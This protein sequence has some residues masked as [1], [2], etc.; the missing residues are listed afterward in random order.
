MRPMLLTL[1]AAM[2][3]PVMVAEARETGDIRGFLEDT[4]GLPVANARVVLKDGAISGEREV[5][6]DANGAFGF[7]NIP[8]GDYNL[9]VYWNDIPAIQAAVR[10]DIN[11]TTSLPLE[12]DLS[13]GVEEIE[14]VTF[15]PVIDSTSSANSASIGSEA[16]ENLPVGRDYR[17]VVAT[18][19]G[20]SGRTNTSDGDTNVVSPSVRGEG[21]Y[22]NNFML[23]GVSIRDPATKTPQQNVNFDAIEEV[24][25]YTDGAP[26]EFGQFTG[27]VV[28]VVT[29]D[30]ANHHFG[31]ASVFY[32]QHAWF[33]SEYDILNPDTDQEEPTT[34][35]K[36]RTPQV[37][38]TFGGPIIEDKLWYF[39]AVQG[40]YSWSIP[41]G[42]NADFPKESW[43]GS[44]FFKL[45]WFPSEKTTVRFIV[46]DTYNNRTSDNASVVIEPDAYRNRKSNTL[47][48]LATITWRPDYT[49]DL[50]TRIGAVWTNGPNVVPASDDELTPQRTN[51]AGII[52]DNYQNYDFNER[53]RAGGG[54]TYTKVWEEALGR[55]K[56]KTGAEYWFLRSSREILN[57][58]RTTIPWIDSDG[59]VIEDDMRDVGTRYTGDS[60]RGLNC[61]AAD[62]SDCA[63]REHWTNVGPLG[64]NVHTIFAF[65]Q[66]DWSPIRQL[67]L[68]L[69]V[70]MDWER[71]LNDE[72]NPPETLSEDQFNPNPFDSQFDDWDP[73]EPGTLGGIA[74]FSPRVGFAW[75]ITGDNKTKLSG[76]YGHYYDLAGGNFWEWSNAR[77]ANGFVR[78]ANDGDGN[79][80]WSNTQDPEGHPLIYSEQLKPARLEKVNVSFE[81]ELIDLF[82]VG[83]RGIWSRTKNI[84]EDVNVNWDDWYIMNSPIK[85]RGYRAFELTLNKRFDGVWQLFGSYTLSESFGHMPGQFELEAGGSSGSD[86]N[87]VG[88]YL[89]DVGEQNVRKSMFD[90]GYG[91][92]LDWLNGLGRYSLTDADFNDD[93]GYY[94]YL[95]YDTRHQFKLNGTYTMPWG[96]T[97]GAVYE[98]VS[99]RAWQKQTLVN[100][101]GY[102]GMGQ[103]RGTRQ[104]PWVN[105]LDFRVAQNVYFKNDSSLEFTVDLFNIL[106][107]A[108]SIFY[109]QADTP[110]FGTTIQRQAPRSIRLGAVYRWN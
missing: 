102:N 52:M 93:A 55:H 51:G 16:M 91:V 64:N 15:T 58:G 101:Y 17:D 87:N 62:Y 37:Y 106:G 7:D 73:G 29:K 68:N 39:G 81:R 67:T 36:F 70:R 48:G 31:S 23:D 11:R 43:N 83:V 30:G 25:V 50:V 3:M 46:N 98:V 107:L 90:Q 66:D 5:L 94:G 4:D 27:M 61:E 78:F 100:F 56:F 86:G 24:Q 105:Y 99:P 92:Y 108:Q 63:F 45:T 88:V 22:G 6:T 41:E 47:N 34:K 96:T 57:T 28:N 82:S 109:W 77:S 65:I 69:G 19:P 76:H 60:S 74:M 53:L 20:V 9:T 103:G 14:V 2:M 59:N 13:A 110:A 80:V 8:P 72:G 42:A 71:G 85:E 26:A 44:A 49:S 54:L 10:V 75:D 95:P 32:T 79:W 12:I 21:E 35:A 84:P 40:G 1:A 38:G 18:L 33:Q 89:D 104:M 97:V